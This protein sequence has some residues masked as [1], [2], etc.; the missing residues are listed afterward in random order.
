MFQGIEMSLQQHMLISV[1]PNEM[2]VIKLA[3]WLPLLFALCGL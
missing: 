3:S 2:M 1:T